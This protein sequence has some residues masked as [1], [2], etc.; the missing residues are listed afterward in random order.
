[1]N[2]KEIMQNLNHAID[3]D[4]LTAVVTIFSYWHPLRSA[5]LSAEKSIRQ[6]VGRAS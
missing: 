2:E 4:N 5:N 6:N 3:K 1:M